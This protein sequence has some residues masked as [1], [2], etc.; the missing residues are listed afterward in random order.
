M[1]VLSRKVLVLTRLNG[2]VTLRPMKQILIILVSAFMFVGCAQLGPPMGGPQDRTPPV[3]LEA[4]PIPGSTNVDTSTTITLTFDERVKE[5][6]LRAAFGLSPP[7]PGTVRAKW[8]GGKRV[9]ISFETALKPDLTYAVTIGTQL[10]DSK[11]NKLTDTYVLAFSTGDKLD[12]G[13]LKGSLLTEGE[14]IGWDIAGYY[15]ADSTTVPDPSTQPPD[16]T[17]QTGDD[18]TWI[19]SNLA[20]GSWRVFAFKDMD[21]DRLWT[22]WS[23]QLAV[24]SYDVVASE[25]SSSVPRELI[26]HPSDPVLLPQVLRITAILKDFFLLRL[27]VKPR[28]LDV[29]YTLTELPVDTMESNREERDWEVVADDLTIPVFSKGFR[30]GDSTIVQIGLDRIPLG[31]AVGLR[32][33][34]SFGTSDTLDTTLTVDL[35]N[36]ALVDTLR[37]GLISVS[38]ED[39]ARMHRGKNQVLLTFNEP[40]RLTDLNSIELMAGADERLP[41]EI[42]TPYPNSVSF[43]IDP[44]TE[45]GGLTL[46]IYGETVVDMMGNS[47]RDSLITYRYAW[48]PQDSLGTLSGEVVAPGGDAPVHLSFTDIMGVQIPIALTLPGAGEFLLNDV[49]A[50]KWQVHGWQDVS[51]TLNWFEGRAIPFR[52]SDP[53]VVSRDTFDVRARWET[54]G[55]E[56]IFP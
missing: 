48:L 32:V 16:A 6:T 21:G 33:V 38:P 31:E 7:P 14:P 41:I 50:G 17:T 3:I 43:D 2:G 28:E 36:A 40:V 22:P 23:D 54:G 26:L 29:S 4:F 9:E 12:T 5:S 13:W 15:L 11:N 18:G 45:G 46:N 10:T 30:P 20:E 39:R 24:P 47:L 19:L 27:D 25:D 44:E 49:P 35:I 1:K 42:K 52:P 56:I 53:V 51:R 37:P 34:G 55:L 8:S